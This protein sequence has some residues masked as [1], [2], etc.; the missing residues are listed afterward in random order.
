M[1]FAYLFLISCFLYSSCIRQE[2]HISDREKAVNTQMGQSAKILSEKYNMHPCGIT[3]AM[4][5]GDIQYLEIEFTIRG[6]LKQDA[7]RKILINSVQDFLNNINKN[8][9][10]CSYLKNGRMDISEVGITIF[11]RDAAGYPI[12]EPEISFASVSKGTVEYVR[13]DPNEI[14]I[15]GLKVVEES[16]EEALEILRLQCECPAVQERCNDSPKES[17]ISN[18]FH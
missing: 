9:E 18:K 8:E 5:E 16:Y 12:Y 11:I 14:S 13:R 2:Y 10:L 15:K 3:V 7:I 1:K 17:T 4:P 6:P